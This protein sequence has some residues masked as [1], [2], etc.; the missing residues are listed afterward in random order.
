MKNF[1]QIKNTG[2]ACSRLY[3]DPILIHN[4]KVQLSNA[5]L[6]VKKLSKAFSLA[7]NEVRFQILYLIH[8]EG[9]L[10]VCDL[11]DILEMKIPAVSQHLRKLK[12][13][14]ILSTERE[15]QIIYYFLNKNYRDFFYP[16]FLTIL[17][18]E[19]EKLLPK[20]T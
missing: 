18:K 9:R 16:G 11:S 8:N 17:K 12:D 1:E 15:G 14:G 2:T 7:G 3:A 20:Q 6:L 13:G 5:E 10:C 4:C 19:E